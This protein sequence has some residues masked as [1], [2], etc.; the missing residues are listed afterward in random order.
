MSNL[1]SCSIEIVLVIV[2]Q[3]CVCSFIEDIGWD[4]GPKAEDREV[5]CSSTF[6]FL[7]II[8]PLGVRR[9]TIS[10]NL[11]KLNTGERVAA[12]MGYSVI[13]GEHKVVTGVFYHFLIEKGYSCKRSDAGTPG[14]T[15]GVPA[16]P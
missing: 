10:C 15:K 3:I 4:F 11:Y 14:Q 2:L 7:S 9:G 16:K 12:V 6:P 1:N 5:I 8:I 13:M